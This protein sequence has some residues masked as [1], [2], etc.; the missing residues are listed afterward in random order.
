MSTNT[1]LFD[2]PLTPEMIAQTPV[3]PRDAAKLLVMDKKEGLL[4]DKHIS[5][6]PN[7]LRAGDVLVFN[8]S[9]V[10]KARLMAIQGDRSFEVF[11]LGPVDRGW[12]ALI[13]PLKKLKDGDR[14]HFED[15]TEATLLCRDE[16][17]IALLDFARSTEDVFA[18]ADRLGA[19]PTPPYLPQQKN[20][21]RYQTIYAK[22]MGSVAAPTAGLHFTPRLMA[23][24]KEKGVMTAFVTLHVGLGTFRPMQTKTI[25]EHKMHKEWASIPKETIEMIRQAKREG[26]RVIAV[27][28]TSTRTLEAWA[29]SDQDAVHWSSS[30]HLFIMPGFS[31]RVIDGLLT[32]FHLPKST[33]LVLVS[34]FMGRES[35][36]RAYAHARE[37]GYR[38]LSFGD[39]M[40]IV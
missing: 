2:Y 7:L 16:D 20:L 3:E 29:L 12:Q 35:M 5:D 31:F 4:S 13:K 8:D 24:L 34:A 17:G 26:R 33:L 14:L 18:I 38:F 40:L 11:L 10:F 15:G 27:G 9:K 22:T 21:D 36:L 39:A 1:D 23:M 28:T 30:V 25:E 19:V 6:L 32:N 37:Y